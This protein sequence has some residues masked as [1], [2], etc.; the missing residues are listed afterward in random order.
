[1]IPL[2]MPSWKIELA[3]WYWKQKSREPTS[4]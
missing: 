4:S 3:K 1:L 2:P